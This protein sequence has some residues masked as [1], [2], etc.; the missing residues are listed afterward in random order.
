MRKWKTQMGLPETQG[1]YGFL[2]VWIIESFG[3][4]LF[5]PLSILYFQATTD[6]ALPII[7]LTLT[8]AT[9]CTIPL[10][11]IAGSLVDQF[12]ARRVT[13]SSLLVQAVGF[14]G[15]LLVRAVPVLF[16]TALL[17]T[18]GTRMFYAASSSLVVEIGPPHERDRW[19]GLV[20]AIRNASGGIG[21]FLA[22][23]VLAINNRDIYHLLIGSCA[24]CYLVAGCLLL[25]L[26]DPKYRVVEKAAN[27]P[28][29][30]ML[31]DSL[32]LGFLVGNIAFPLCSLMLGTAF[33]IY[34]TEA[35]HAPA[36]IV[37]PILIM[38]SLMIISCQTLVVRLLEPYRRT[39]AIGSAAL[40][41]CV[42]CCLFVLA[43][44]IPHAF[45]VPY[46]FLAVALHTL[47]SLLYGP[48][49]GALVAE[50][51]PVPLRGRYLATYE[52]TWGVASAL[53]PALFTV[54]YAVKPALPWI[55]VAVLVFISGMSIL[56]LER[57]L[58]SRA[59]RV[60]RQA[61]EC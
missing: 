49:T 56:W 4:G 41:W 61:N 6:I 17:V 57:R 51:G 25:R 30:T 31:R 15:Y 23:L 44:V 55:I 5:V 9:I 48:A 12:G 33:P 2:L 24:I 18:A 53:T 42:A 54:L 39:R 35:V 40:V 10:T 36:W 19:F 21:G 3:S 20:G 16:M 27:A 1:T 38:N 58:P 26:P 59:V 8:I 46:L 14:A 28:Y 60:E 50:L 11:L 22:G 13:A 7:G 47:A 45:L 29:G 37:G 34:V 43:L 52:F 32:F